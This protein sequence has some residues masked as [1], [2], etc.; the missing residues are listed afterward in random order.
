MV[1]KVY[2]NIKAVSSIYKTILAIWVTVIGLLLNSCSAT[3]Y[4]SAIQVEDCTELTTDGVYE[5][6]E[7]KY[8]SD[9]YRLAFGIGTCYNFSG[10]QTVVL[11]F[12][13]DDESSWSKEDVLKFTNSKVL[14]SLDFLEK[15]AKEWGVELSFEVK[16]FSTPLS[17]GTKFVYEGC[18]N[19]NLDATGSTKDLPEQMS[20]ILGYKNEIEFFNVMMDEYQSNSVI[21]IMLLNKDGTAYARKQLVGGD[22]G[23]IEH[24]VVFADGLGDING[25]WRYVAHR[26][27]TIAHEILHLF[28][29]EDYYIN[30]KRLELAEEH[31]IDDIMLLD[32]YDIS[33]LKVGEMTAY[34]VGWTD[35]APNIR[36]YDNWANEE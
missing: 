7:Y 23:H 13:D 24:A 3:S 1:I 31:Y 14:P 36:Y 20:K 32:T 9:S 25:S 8:A 2:F 12:V 28:G 22:M 18:V 35:E 33:R 5:P 16:R 29:A 15:Q 27:A 6:F 30:P 19:K 26:E 10:K 34:Y 21:P 4:G 17:D 11:F